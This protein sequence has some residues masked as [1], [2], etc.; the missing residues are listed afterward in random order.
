MAAM[1]IEHRLFMQHNELPVTEILGNSDRLTYKN[2]RQRQ[3]SS[4]V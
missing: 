1:S 3:P 2:N 4:A